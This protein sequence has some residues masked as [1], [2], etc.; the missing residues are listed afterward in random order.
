[1]RRDGEE[2]RQRCERLRCFDRDFDREAWSRGLL[3]GVDEAGVGPLA[4]PV[5]AAAVILPA[6][7]DLPEVFDSKQMRP[8]AR[9][10]CERDIR[11]RALALGVASVSPR[12]ID[13]V[14]ILHAMLQAQRRAL[15]ALDLVP[16]AVIVDGCRT[17]S[18]PS[19]WGATR[20][21]AVVRADS[22]SLAV[23]AASVVAKETRD[24]IMLR[25]D[26]R[27][28]EYGFARHKGYGTAAHKA[29]L[30]RHGPSPVHR[31]CFCTWLETEAAAARQGVFE[32]APD[33]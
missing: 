21:Q 14:H 33:A 18:L 8:A 25:L 23:A 12:R 1:M 11:A 20:L 10:R 16:V 22:Q 3:A 13:R 28:P 15:A 9:Q 27:Y 5:V 32:F 24:R 17:P 29:A 26:R 7:F 30:R 19:A 31:L 4:G 2:L 6:D